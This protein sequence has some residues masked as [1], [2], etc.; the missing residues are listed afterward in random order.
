MDPPSCPL[1][2]RVQS[3][4]PDIYEQLIDAVNTD[5]RELGGEVSPTVV[6]LPRTQHLRQRIGREIYGSETAEALADE[7][8][9]VSELH[10][11][12]PMRTCQ[13]ERWDS[14]SVFVI[15]YGDTIKREGEAPLRTCTVS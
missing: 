12:A 1:W 13:A 5:M 7:V 2:R 14:S 11:H 8:L 3:A 15:T 9:A 6:R 10:G 4:I